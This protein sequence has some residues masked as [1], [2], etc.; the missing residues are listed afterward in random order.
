MLYYVYVQYHYFLLPLLKQSNVAVHCVQHCLGTTLGAFSVNR[1]WRD[2][3]SGVPLHFRFII[4]KRNNKVKSKTEGLSFL[5]FFFHPLTF[6]QQSTSF[7]VFV[8]QRPSGQEKRQI[9][10]E[11]GNNVVSLTVTIDTHWQQQADQVSIDVTQT[12]H[13][14]SAPKCT[15]LFW[16]AGFSYF[17]LNLNLY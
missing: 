16:P 10:P 8:L 2:D 9:L 3:Q 12:R 14:N 13:N 17:L 4:I 1:K 15:I 7:L 11:P 5:F 6:T